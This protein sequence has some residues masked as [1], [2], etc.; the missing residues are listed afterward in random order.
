MRGVVIPHERA[1]IMHGAQ[2]AL[3]RPAEPLSPRLAQL[4]REAWCLLAVGAGAFLALVLFSYDAGDPAWSTS[5]GHHVA[6][7]RG[8]PIGAWLADLL[9][10]LFGI[11]AWWWVGL[12]LFVIW[13]SYQRIESSP[14]ID[15]R[16]L[17]IAALGFALLIL[18]SSGLE[19]LRFHSH[20]L[21][22]PMAPGGVAGSLMAG[23]AAQGFGFTGGTLGLL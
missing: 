15:R 16:P 7:N 8:G 22:L 2:S 11:S 20:R 13:A 17:Y 23:V 4:L 19:S 3:K 18:A 6:L 1:L 14:L 9:L 10:Y 5:G 12:A 21:A